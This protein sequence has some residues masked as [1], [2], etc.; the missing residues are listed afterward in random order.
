[1]KRMALVSGLLFF[2]MTSCNT[3]SSYNLAEFFIKYV[4]QG[5]C[6]NITITNYGPDD[7][8]FSRNKSVIVV[9][10]GSSSSFSPIIGSEMRSD[11]SYSIAGGVTKN[12]GP[13]NYDIGF[14]CSSTS[15]ELRQTYRVYAIVTLTEDSTTPSGLSVSV[16][17]PIG[18]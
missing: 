6:P 16:V 15:P 18:Y 2:S 3:V 17:P 4:P 1:M 12:G 5:A 14:K 9:K 13:H 10:V 7:I 8:D 11:G